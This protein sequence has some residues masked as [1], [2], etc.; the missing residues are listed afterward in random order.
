[1]YIPRL[2]DCVI[3]V[4]GFTSETI[5]TREQVKS[6]IDVVGAC[7]LGPL[8]KDYTTHL[9]CYDE[10]SDKYQAVKSWGVNIHVVKCEWLFECMKRWERVDEAEYL[11]GEEEKMEEEKKVDVNEDS[12]STGDEEEDEEE[13]GVNEDSIST[14]DEEE[15]EV[16]AV[17]EEKKVDEVERVE[18]KKVE[19]KKV[20]EKKVEEKK[21]EEKKVE[22]KMKEEQMKVIEVEEKKKVEEEEEEE[23]K[24]EEEIENNQM[25][26]EKD[27]QIEESS[28][29]SLN[30]QNNSIYTESETLS[31]SKRSLSPSQT[32]SSKRPAITDK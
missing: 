22:E 28:N 26:E 6:A 13:K 24:V 29:I 8:C 12:I 16:E 1:M 9:I 14:G 27:V 10:R 3:S 20:E 17:K 30:L 23:K 2:R 11:L 21:V 15:I 32:P 7:Y 25:E 19:E 4:T 5:P 18:E 31:S